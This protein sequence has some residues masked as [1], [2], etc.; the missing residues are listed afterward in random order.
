MNIQSNINQGL[1]LMSLLISQSPMAEQQR[2]RAR[3]AEE[4]KKTQ[5]QIEK[6]EEMSEQGREPETPVEAE[7][8]LSIARVGDEAYSRAFEQTPS[9]KTYQ[10]ML[11]QKRDI[12]ELSQ[13]KAD[14]QKKKAEDA[15]R[16]E[17]TRLNEDKIRRSILEGVYSTDP[18]FDP[19]YTG[20]KK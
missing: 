7:A 14:L 20:G 15:L 12:A 3:E 4:R 11:R 8:Q 19:R 16:V 5:R 9:E 2:I 17:Q 1:S 10:D 18:A 6:Y 13:T